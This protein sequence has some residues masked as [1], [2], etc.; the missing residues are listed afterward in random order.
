MS[1]PVSSPVSTPGGGHGHDLAG[2]MVSQMLM[3]AMMGRQQQQ[4]SGSWADTAQM[5][6]SC[7]AMSVV[8]QLAGAAGKA[9]DFVVRRAADYAKRLFTSP[10]VPIV[11]VKEVSLEVETQS[12]VYD[13]MWYL[14]T[15]MNVP[16]GR[17]DIKGKL[18]TPGIVNFPIVPGVLCTVKETIIEQNMHTVKDGRLQEI[19]AKTMAY[20]VVLRTHESDLDLDR[21]VE[22]MHM[23]RD[24]KFEYEAQSKVVW[25]YRM[26]AAEP[27][28]FT[29]CNFATSK[30]FDNIYI[31][32]AEHD[33]LMQRLHLFQTRHDWYKLNGI[34]HTFTVLLH[35]PPGTGKTSFIKALAAKLGRHPCSYDLGLVQTPEQIEALFCDDQLHLS[36]EGSVTVSIEKRLIILEEIDCQSDLFLSREF[37]STAEP[38]PV[39]PD[40][41]GKVSGTTMMIPMP[42]RPTPGHLYEAL[43]GLREHPNP[44][45]HGRVIVM[46]TNH[47]DKLDPAIMRPGRI[48]MVIRL[49]NI[50]RACIR[51]MV[52]NMCN[53][54][55]DANHDRIDRVAAAADGVLT[56]AEAMSCVQAAYADAD[57]ACTRIEAKVAEK[58]AVEPAAMPSPSP[59]SSPVLKLK[60]GKRRGCASSDGDTN[61]D[62]GGASKRVCA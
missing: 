13:I 36:G 9:T 45:G 27:V 57:N 24:V 55:D 30:S 28:K 59:S 21:L 11:P 47:I 15:R 33:I 4:G 8:P 61:S 16:N 3:V 25:H 22:V 20:S 12:N 32:A 37:H 10:V 43:D 38:H 51:R 49:G 39:Q 44:K 1:S 58:L 48:D 23:C 54:A 31:A 52:R 18:V 6:L 62:D 29:R 7:S 19:V 14:G 50:D 46:T 26:I 40:K 5:A 41:N 42:S 2:G 17:M 34:P 35:G 56:P 60:G 53:V